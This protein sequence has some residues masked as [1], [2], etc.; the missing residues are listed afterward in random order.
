LDYIGT[1]K[2]DPRV[3]D[4][5]IEGLTVACREAGASLIGGETAEM[6]G[7]YEGTDYDLVGSVTGIVDQ[8]RIIDGSRIS[9][10]DAILG[11]PS[12]GLHTNGY[13]LARKVLLENMNLG[14]HDPLPGADCTVAEELLRVH[15]NY[16]PL[17]QPLVEKDMLKGIAHITG[18]G[19]IDNV[20]RILPESVDAQIDTGTWEIPHVFRLIEEHSNSSRSEMYHAFNMGIGMV[21]VVN[22]DG[23][24][25]AAEEL[26]AIRIGKIIAGQGQTRLV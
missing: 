18:G 12:N 19:L 15:K 21:V 24:D 1:G 20:P 11:L 4:E 26:G 14:I 3:F 2:L 10:G 9:I 5:L 25:A 16:Q 17:L 22:E 8:A 7:V 13:S 6:P 23:A